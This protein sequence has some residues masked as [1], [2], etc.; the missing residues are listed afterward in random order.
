MLRG[1]IHFRRN[2]HFPPQIVQLDT[3]RSQRVRWFDSLQFPPKVLV[4]C[5]QN[6]GP[7]ARYR[8]ARP[9][10]WLGLRK[11][12]EPTITALDHSFHFGCIDRY[13]DGTGASRIGLMDARETEAS[14]GTRKLNAAL[15][16]LGT[17]HES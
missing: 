1:A 2:R 14:N 5:R 11:G 10:F 6:R 7:R 17:S 4:C 15:A 9:E 16:V 8:S 13:L 3:H 12:M